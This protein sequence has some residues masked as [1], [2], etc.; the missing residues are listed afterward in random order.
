MEVSGRCC[1]VI[2]YFVYTKG[3][4]ILYYYNIVHLQDYMV[5]DSTHTIRGLHTSQRLL[6]R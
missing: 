5:E 2:R 1:T 3:C 6:K 4:N